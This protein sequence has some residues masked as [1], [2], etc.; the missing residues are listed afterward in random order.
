MVAL[1]SHPKTSTALYAFLTSIGLSPAS[2]MSALALG[3]TDR[4]RA[5]LQALMTVADLAG[6]PPELNHFYVARL[7]GEAYASRLE[8][9]HSDTPVDQLP[10]TIL[11]YYQ[12][13]VIKGEPRL[14]HCRLV[15]AVELSHLLDLVGLKSCG[16]TVNYPYL[17]RP[18]GT[19][20]C[21]VGCRQRHE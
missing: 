12:N 17:S 10:V 21:P 6:C 18:L 2:E 4:Q 16:N 3:M 9:I 8:F 1:T 11:R 5:N 14:T 20:L 7:R 19:R 15:P 13:G